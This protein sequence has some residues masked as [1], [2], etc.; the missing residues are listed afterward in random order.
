VVLWKNK[1]R[2]IC[3]IWTFILVDW[4]GKNGNNS[5]QIVFNEAILWSIDDFIFRLKFQKVYHPS[6]RAQ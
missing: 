6:C 4:W 1:K 5:F 2:G 3:V